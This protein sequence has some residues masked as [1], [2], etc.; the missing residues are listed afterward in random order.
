MHSAL[1]SY[2]S[3]KKYVAKGGG[4]CLSY[5]RGKKNVN[6]KNM[7]IKKNTV[8][9]ISRGMPINATHSHIDQVLYNV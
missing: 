6:D 2:R 1:I 8:N 5:K 4:G 3:E 9:A 7:K